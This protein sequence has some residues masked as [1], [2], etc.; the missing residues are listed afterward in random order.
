VEFNDVPEDVWCRK[1]VCFIAAR[2]ISK[3]TGGGNFSPDAKLARGQFI[4]MLMKSYDIDPDP[5]SKDNFA[6]AG[7]TYYT[8]YLAAAKRLKIASGIGNN[9]FAPD[10]EITRQEMFTLLYNALKAIGRLPEGT[11]GKPLT[12]FSDIEYIAPWASEAITLLVQTGTIAGDSG[13]IY[14]LSISTR[15]EMAQLMYNLLKN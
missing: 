11:E 5:D 14:P 13:K 6:D 8:D 15:A 9:L 1:A 10:K 2:E 3:G 7:N 4:V 12:A